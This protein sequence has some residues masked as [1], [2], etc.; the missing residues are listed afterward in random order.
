[1]QAIVPIMCL[2]VAMPW[3][4]GEGGAASHVHFDGDLWIRFYGNRGEEDSYSQ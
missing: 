2:T 3:R 4:Y 1:M